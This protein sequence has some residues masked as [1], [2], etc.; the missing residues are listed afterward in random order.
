M[1]VGIIGSTGRMGVVLT[2]LILSSENFDLSG[3]ISSKSSRED[4][5]NVVKESE[6]LIDFSTP[7]ATFDALESAISHKKAFITGTTGFSVED[8]VK[9]RGYARSIP[10]LHA[11]NFSL[12]IQLIGLLLEKSANA[13]S[14]FDFAIIDKH[15]NRKKDA[16]SGTA[17][18]LENQSGRKAQI[19]SLRLGNIFGDHSCEFASDNEVITFSH[20]ALNRRVFAEGALNCAH[21]LVDRGAGFY[22]MRDYLSEKIGV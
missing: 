6:I 15:H 14:D 7:S 12:G 20:T 22:S 1:K 9:M 5:E 2:D 18:F 19:V 8:M 17:L 13:L 16:P 3:G 11:S 10:V 4:L 21:W